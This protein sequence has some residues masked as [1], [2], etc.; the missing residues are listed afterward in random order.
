MV[1]S[2]ASMLGSWTL[3]PV[4]DVLLEAAPRGRFGLWSSGI[5]IAHHSRERYRWCAVR[6]ASPGAGSAPSRG[7]TRWSSWPTSLLRRS[8]CRNGR[9]GRAA[10]HRYTPRIQEMICTISTSSMNTC[11]RF[12]ATVGS[13]TTT[14]TSTTAIYIT[15]IS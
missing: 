8:C 7:R 6:G 12:F 5:E 9:T 1:E 3:A 14:S 11:S 15:T 4:Q 10:A 13:R 2:L